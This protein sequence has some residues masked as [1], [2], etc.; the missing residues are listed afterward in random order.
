MIT[1]KPESEESGAPRGALSTVEQESSKAAVES[2]AFDPWTASV[3]DSLQLEFDLEDPRSHLW[4]F[5]TAT[6]L[7]G[8]RSE[9][10]EGSGLDVLG[11]VALCAL[12]GL[13][14]PDWIAKPFLERFR[15]VEQMQVGSWDAAEAFG[16]PHRGRHVEQLRLRSDQKQQV[17]HL[18]AMFVRA[19]PTVPV[20]SQWDDIADSIGIRRQKAEELH[21]EGIREQEFYDPRKIRVSLGYPEN[22]K[23]RRPI[24]RVTGK[25]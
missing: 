12:H 14:L 2:S 20:S 8:R 19:N 25:R 23:K 1:R 22:P 13:V 17:L 3:E 7:K 5:M 6:Q 16:P 18:V 15:A 24:N 11:A 21:A 10:E 9:I 4:Q